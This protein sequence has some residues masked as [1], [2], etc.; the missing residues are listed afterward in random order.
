MT[1]S[2]LLE[3]GVVAC[4]VY[5]C[6]VYGIYLSLLAVAI[7]ES[8]QRRLET[9]ADDHD[10]IAHSRFL[11]PVSVLVPAHNEVGGLPDAVR[12]LLALEYPEFEVIVISDGSTDGTVERLRD[13]FELMPVEL[14]SRAVVATEPVGAV[15]RSHAERRLVVLDKRGGGKADALNVGLNYCRYRFVCGVDADMVFARDALSRAM[16]AFLSDPAQVVGLTSFVEIAENP[17]SAL[18]GVEY[19]IPDSRPFLLFQTLDYLR[20]FFNNRIAWSRLGFMLCAVGAFQV[21]RRE[22]LD[23]LGGWSREFTCEDIELTFRVHRVL[24]ER[25]EPYRVLCLPDRIGVTEGPDTIGKLVAQRE[26]WQRVILETWWA[27]RRMCFNRRYGRVGMLGM[28][29]YLASE[30]VAPAFELLAAATLVVGAALGLVDWWLF[31]LVL[32]LISLVNS[33]FSSASLLM[34]ER[35]SGAYRPTG[36]LRLLAL[37][38]VEILVYRPVLSWARMKGTWR[39]LRGD[40][41]WHKFERN[42]RT[43]PA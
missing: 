43:E 28:P 16:C 19:R 21:W 14:S 35:Q 4:A 38:P 5:L 12:S 30:I 17:A 11:P 23:E 29:F 8:R 40:K 41:A 25:G 42:V 26:R 2:T 39:F 13:E 6:V 31:A 20:A 22:L 32:L 1:V 7:V 37:M 36:L 33:G 34:V 18:R 27:N 3:A 15:F 24:Q 10:T 9:E